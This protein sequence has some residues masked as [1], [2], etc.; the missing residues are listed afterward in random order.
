MTHRYVWGP[1]FKVDGLP[2]LDR[3]GE[4]CRLVKR[5]NLNSAF[6]QW[7]DGE[8]DVVSRNALRKLQ[9]SVAV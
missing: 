4:L 7:Q 6:V 8:Y 1:R 9:L 3:K 2:V 5:L